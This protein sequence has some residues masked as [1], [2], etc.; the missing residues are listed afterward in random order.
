MPE[1]PKSYENSLRKVFIRTFGCQMNNRDS[2]LAYALLAREGYAKAEAPEDA[3]I[4][5]FNTCSVRK[6]AEDRAYGN[7]GLLKDWKKRYPDKM[8]GIIG[9]MA[10]SH[11]EKIFEKLP[12]VDFIC[13]PANIF[14]L[15]QL[16]M[17]LAVQTQRRYIF[18]LN[19]R[20][21]PDIE[22]PAL[23]Q[24]P[25]SAYVSISEG[26]NNFCS[27]CI[28]PYVR[29]SEQSRSRKLILDEIRM[30][31]DFGYK[32]VILLGQNVNSY[33]R[34]G[35]GIRRKGR[36]SE[37]A[38]LLEDVDKIKGIE[39]VRFTTSHPKDAAGD[40]FKAMRDL[41]K[42]CEHLHLPLQ[43]GSSRILNR[44]NRGYAP[45]GYL[46]LVEEYRKI[47]PSAGL[48]TD[49]IVG[50]PGEKETD[51]KDTCKIMKEIKFDGAFIFKY[52]PRPPAKAAEFKDDVPKE[53]KE[54]RNQA[55]LRLQEEISR[56]INEGLA[57]TDVEVFVESENKKDKEKSLS[58]R[59]RT[60]KVAVFGGDA[61]LVK[62]I[63]NLRV[64]RATPHTLIGDLTGDG[65]L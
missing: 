10:Q 40:L 56:K 22:Q 39:R 23:R 6:H 25:V 65:K 16:I 31:A 9:C 53:K 34:K 26:C 4:V 11:G 38:K 44:M 55:L 30:L 54:E 37:F 20:Q 14:D 29:G 59:T 8:L 60:N 61:S 32:E 43:S 24:S 64:K 42:V 12:H 62:K 19:N 49:I 48:T 15:P 51:F 35:Q 41:G 1:K 58:G 18:A 2:E 17:R 45:E 50:F 21:R 52:S 36:R 46:K 27:Y 13:G 7:A 33:Q 57:G 5:L 47:L 28:V 3:D 63:V